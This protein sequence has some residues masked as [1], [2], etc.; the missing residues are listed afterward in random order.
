MP[1]VKTDT[2]KSSIHVTPEDLN[3][4][5]GIAELA[6]LTHAGRVQLVS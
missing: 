2:F 5:K 6:G 1:R 3:K 4:L